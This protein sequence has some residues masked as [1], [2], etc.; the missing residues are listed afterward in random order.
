MHPHIFRPSYGPV[1]CS[2]WQRRTAFTIITLLGCFQFTEVKILQHTGGFPLM[3]ISLVQISLVQIS[4]LRFFKPFQKHS[5]YAI[6]YAIHF[7]TAIIWLF[8]AIL[9]AIYFIT[10][11]N[12]PNAIFG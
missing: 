11:I 4:L 7:V 5:A 9:C 10:V 6:L 1:I 8:N 3:R 12:L 2:L